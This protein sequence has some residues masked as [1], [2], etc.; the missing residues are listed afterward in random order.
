MRKCANY[1]G[2]YHK[3][4]N[5]EISRVGALLAE[6]GILEPFQ[7]DASFEHCFGRFINGGNNAGGLL[8]WL[9]RNPIVLIAI[10]FHGRERE[11]GARD[12][13]HRKLL[14]PRLFNRR[15]AAFLM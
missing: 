10:S 13:G 3:E 8:L 15:K 6:E 7:K 14:E 1:S 4:R 12:E 5:Q 9:L 11:I 2:I